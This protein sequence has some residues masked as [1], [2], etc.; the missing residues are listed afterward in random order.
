LV[1]IYSKERYLNNN[2]IN[3]IELKHPIQI[4]S[5][6]KEQ[7]GCSVRPHEKLDSEKRGVA[8]EFSAAKLNK[9]VP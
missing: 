1:L 3:F 8:H 2:N 5:Q 6:Y 9:G 4:A 7:G